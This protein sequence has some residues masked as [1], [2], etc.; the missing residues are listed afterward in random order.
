MPDPATGQM[1]TEA[2]GGAVKLL[3]Y[4]D[5]IAHRITPSV[6]YPELYTTVDDPV[7]QEIRDAQGR[8]IGQR[9]GFPGLKRDTDFQFKDLYD[10][11]RKTFQR[12]LDSLRQLREIS[13]LDP[14][15]LPIN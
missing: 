2:P 11:A 9:K 13:I 7:W 14:P 1:R 15:L 10:A 6:D 5:R 12:Y 3:D 4:R 8:V